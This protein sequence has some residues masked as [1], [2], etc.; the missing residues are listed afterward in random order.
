MLLAQG[1]V[2]I[3]WIDDLYDCADKRQNTVCGSSYVKLTQHLV[4]GFKNAIKLIV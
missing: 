3:G 2:F 4:L 1:S